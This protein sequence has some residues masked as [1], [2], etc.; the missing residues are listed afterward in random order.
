HEHGHAH[1]GI[2][3]LQ[4]IHHRRKEEQL[5]QV[6]G[7]DDE[8]AALFIDV[9]GEGKMFPAHHATE[10]RRQPSHHLVASLRQL[11]GHLF[12]LGGV[13]PAPIASRGPG[14]VY[15][16]TRVFSMAS[17]ARAIGIKFKSFL[18]ISGISSRSRLFVSGNSTVLIPARWAAITLSF[19]PPMARTWPVS[20]IS[21]VIATSF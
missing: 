1:A 12:N 17:A 21:P 11:G 13:H 3:A 10:E 16:A 4:V 15:S 14:P 18:M 8:H 9:A 20:V 19:K 2:A 5:G 6:A 7:I